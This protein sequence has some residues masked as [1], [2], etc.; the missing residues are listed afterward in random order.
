MTEAS[1]KGGKSPTRTVS[2]TKY[3][4]T[5]LRDIRE[6]SSQRPKVSDKCLQNPFR[7]HFAR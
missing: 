5:A 2:E 7:E 1:F 3:G 6:N 4:V